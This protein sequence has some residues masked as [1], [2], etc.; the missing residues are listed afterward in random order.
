MSSIAVLLICAT[1]I[2]MLVVITFFAENFTSGVEKLMRE[3]SLWSRQ[4]FRSYCGLRG[5][6]NETTLIRKSGSLTSV[7]RLKGSRSVLGKEEYTRI[8]QS[9]YE[10]FNSRMDEKQAGAMDIQFV[11]QQDPN[12]SNAMA[13]IGEA[14]KATARRLGLSMEDYIDS[15]MESVGRVSHDED[16]FIV[17]TTHSRMEPNARIEERVADFNRIKA[18][19]LPRDWI[20]PSVSLDVRAPASDIEERHEAMIRSV[21][22]VDTKELWMELISVDDVLKNIKLSMSQG[23]HPNWVPRIPGRNNPP[24]PD[25]RDFNQPP[26]PPLWSQIAPKVIRE[27]DHREDIVEMDGLFYGVAWVNIPPQT[28]TQFSSLS[29]RLRGI[30]FRISVRMWPAGLGMNKFNKMIVDMLSLFP[31]SYNR[32]IKAAMDDMKEEGKEG[33]QTLGVA[34]TVTTWAK[35]RKD[36]VKQLTLMQTRLQGW[37]G[38]DV[39]TQCGDGIDL[40]MSTI[41]ALHDETP[42]KIM[43]M[44]SYSIS[45]MLPFFTPASVWDLGAVLFTAAQGKLMPFQPGSAEQKTW[46]YLFFAPPGSGKSAMLNTVEIALCL[47]PGQMRM[48]RIVVIDVGD[49]VEGPINLISSSL[50]DH[51]KSEALFVKLRMRPE[52]AFNVFDTDR[53]FRYPTPMSREMIVNFVTTIATPANASEAPDSVFEL[54]GMLIDEAYTRFSDKQEPKRYEPSVSTLVDEALSEIDYKLDSSSSWWEVTDALHKSGK[55]RESEIAQRYAVPTLADLPMLLASPSINDIYGEAGASGA[56]KLPKF[57]GRMISSVLRDYPIF[58]RPTQFDLGQGRFIGIDLNDVRGTGDSGKKQTALMYLFAMSLATRNFF[59]HKDMLLDIPHKC[60]DIYREFHVARVKELSEE[61]KSLIMDEFHNTGG[62]NSIR[63][64]VSVLN[65]EGRKHNV[66]VALSSQL[67]EHFDNDMVEN[68]TGTFVMSCD[69]SAMAE[70][71]GARFGLSRSAI[72]ALTGVNKV[73]QFMGI[74]KTKDQGTT[75][76]VMRNILS[77]VKYWAFTTTSEDKRL[78]SILYEKLTPTMARKQMAFFY[79][80]GVKIEY[81]RRKMAMGGDSDEVVTSIIDD[82]AEEIIME[83]HRESMRNSK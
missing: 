29:D 61:L 1:I 49:S 82:I 35:D 81:E 46:N 36:C 72:N 23:T 73:G 39:E 27:D 28:E 63:R 71:I 41:P 52:Y 68:A 42:A 53:G 9:F 16:C 55:Q 62:L 54:I 57:V 60:P 2:S 56:E 83:Y 30:P 4:D 17:I 24:A 6:L 31:K 15:E 11:F 77:P 32:R 13:K 58:G 3:L 10:L 37:G 50:P 8:V 22:D 20:D 48:P 5:I 66:M 43:P 14:I 12:T 64:M 38:C 51:R 67:I 40:L 34:I 79:P 25:V 76:H 69:N 59:A 47:A 75:T 26:Y 78:R 21:I 18:A 33:N 70:K 45:Q 65:L 44:T 19:N 7:I 74:F 80:K